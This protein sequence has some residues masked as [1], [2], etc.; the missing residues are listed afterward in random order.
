ME[1]ISIGFSGVVFIKT[2]TKF[3]VVDHENYKI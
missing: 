1:V 2:K 3:K